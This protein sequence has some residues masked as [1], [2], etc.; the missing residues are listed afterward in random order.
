MRTTQVLADHRLTATHRIQAA[1][2][3]PDGKINEKLQLGALVLD[4][5]QFPRQ[6]GEV[7][8]CANLNGSHE[9]RRPNEAPDTVAFIRRPLGGDARWIQPRCVAKF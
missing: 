7:L 6:A 8:N 5:V 3:Q 4:R 9:A 2:H 1:A